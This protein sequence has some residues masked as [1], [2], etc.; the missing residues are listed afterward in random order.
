M[1]WSPKQMKAIRAKKHGWNPPGDK[2]PF[3]KVGKGKLAEMEKEGTKSDK[4]EDKSE[5]GGKKGGFP[6]KRQM[7]SSLQSQMMALKGGK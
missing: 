7:K 1:P 5:K 4:S 3:A 2:E 6:F